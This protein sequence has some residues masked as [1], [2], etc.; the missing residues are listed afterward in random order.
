MGPGQKTIYGKVSNKGKVVG[1]NFFWGM[2]RFVRAVEQKSG[3][4]IFKKYHYYHF[5]RVIL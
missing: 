5:T 3:D 4:Q 2:K 1:R